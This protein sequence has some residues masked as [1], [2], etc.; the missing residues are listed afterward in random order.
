MQ[1]LI[2]GL[3]KMTDKEKLIGKLPSEK[4]TELLNGKLLSL[5]GFAMRAGKLSYG[6]DK[7]CDDIR[8]HGIP[9]DGD[10]VPKHPLGIVLVAS[11]A[12][13]NTKKRIVNACTYYNVNYY[14]TGIPSDELGQRIGRNSSAAVCAV[15]DRD[16]TSGISKAVSAFD[17]IRT[18]R[19]ERS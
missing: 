6:T 16:F 1:N 10:G 8:R 9:D 5:L 18:D 19:S 15:F 12:S 13:A 7:V 11:D 3:Q 17:G 14:V 4:Q 2:G